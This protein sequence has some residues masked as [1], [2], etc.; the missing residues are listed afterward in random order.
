M[1]YLPRTFHKLCLFAFFVSALLIGGNSFAVENGQTFKEWVAECQT[2]PDTQAQNC[3][4]RQEVESNRDAAAR[5]TMMVIPSRRDKGFTAAL[6]APL[7][8]ALRPGLQL[9]VDSLEP[10]KATFE[11]CL[12]DGCIAYVDLKG[13]LLA[14]LK[15]GKTLMVST[16]AADGRQL[17]VPMSLAGFTAATGALVK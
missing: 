14:S 2:Q 13:E 16:K 1:P 10:F 8:T 7:G 9:Q 12:P 6:V 4:I 11:F 15:K 17:D 3:H 5:L